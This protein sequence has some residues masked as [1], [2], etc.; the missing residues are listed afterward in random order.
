MTPLI[1]AG[2]G[3][4]LGLVLPALVVLGVVL[5]GP[6]AELMSL[7]VG[8]GRFEPYAEIWNDSFYW[9]VIAGSFR[10]AA[11]TSVICLLLAYPLSYFLATAR[12][13]VA[14]LGLAFVLLPFWTSLLIRTYAWMV[15]LGR[16]GVINST[17]MGLGL[18][19]RPVALMYNT[20]GVIIGTVHYLLPFM[21]FPVYAA[22]KRVDPNLMLAAYGLG[23]THWGVFRKVYLPLTLNG[24]FAG[25]ALVFIISLSAYV[26]PALLGGGRVVMIA[27]LIQMQVSQLLNWPLAG[28]LSVAIMVA[29]FAVYGLMGLITGRKHDGA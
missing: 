18:I 27:N 22:M 13:S 17:L 2:E 3:R 26:T 23:A 5:F 16:S 19:D 14:A 15:L 20:T 25:F 7:T 10:I 12:P 9:G 4:R 1:P 28:A 24:V 11:L 29:A 21:V 8:S 6:L